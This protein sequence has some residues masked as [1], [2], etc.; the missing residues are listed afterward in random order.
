MIVVVVYSGDRGI[1][2]QKEV[3]EYNRRED[4]TTAET[5]IGQSGFRDTSTC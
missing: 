1:R 4:P 2:R 5:D 3:S